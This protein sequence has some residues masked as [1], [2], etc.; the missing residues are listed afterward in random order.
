MSCQIILLHFLRSLSWERSLTYVVV[1]FCPLMCIIHSW[2]TFKRDKALKFF[3]DY[4]P[5]TL[6]L[7][8][9]CLKFLHFLTFH[10]NRHL[11][12]IIIIAWKNFHHLKFLPMWILLCL[13]F[14]LIGI[15]CFDKRGVFFWRIRASEFFTIELGKFML[16]MKLWT[17]YDYVHRDGKDTKNL[18][19]QW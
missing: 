12:I 5:C 1:V 15:H 7:V 9:A 3:Y 13:K 18:K 8:L 19:F 17:G 10:M 11:N 6:L 14:P 2:V 4:S 16:E